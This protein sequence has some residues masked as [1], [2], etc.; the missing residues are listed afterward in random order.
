MTQTNDSGDR[1]PTFDDLRRHYQTGRSY[2]L[3]GEG[4]NKVY[5]Y[6]NGVMCNL[7]DIERSEWQK[8]M[9]ELIHR[10]GEDELHHQLTLWEREHCY[11]YQSR[12]NL[13]HHVLELHAA[14]FFDNPEWVYFIPFNQKHRP[15]A[16]K[17]ISL[18]TVCTECCGTPFLTTQARIDHDGKEQTYCGI[19]GR[20]SPYQ[21]LSADSE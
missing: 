12:E 10:A 6:R 8:M 21:I 19:C 11:F 7:G 14:Q 9:R 1:L 18:V 17:G 4:R 15:D 2:L 3:S 20:W 5:G 16:L 13:E